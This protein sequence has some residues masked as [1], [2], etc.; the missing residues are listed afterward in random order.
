[1]RDIR[2]PD[3]HFFATLNH[4]PQLGIPGAYIGEF[5]FEI[6]S[7]HSS[8]VTGEVRE[9][10][11]KP[12]KVY[13]PLPGACS[14]FQYFR[15]AALHTFCNG[16]CNALTVPNCEGSHSVRLTASKFLTR[17][18]HF[19][20]SR[21]TRSRCIDSTSTFH[22]ISFFFVLPE[23]MCFVHYITGRRYRAIELIYCIHIEE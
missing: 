6:C 23:I 17:S 4:N 19:I 15:G 7:A 8:V 5:I 12:S 9:F 21:L 22:F 10:V 14:T 3:E 11:Y 1:M 18:S 20:T 13:R 16:C 2:V